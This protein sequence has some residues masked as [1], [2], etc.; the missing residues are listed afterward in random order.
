MA[1]LLPARTLAD[2]LADG[3]PSARFPQSGI[4]GATLRRL[5]SRVLRATSG[6]AG[7]GYAVAKRT[8][9]IVVAGAALAFAAPVLALAAAAIKL[10]SKGPVL[11]RQTRIGKDGQPF[12]MWKLRSMYAD[13]EARKAALAATSERTGA[14]KLKHDPRITRVGRLIRKASL[15]EIPQLF[16]VLDGTMSLVGPRPPLPDEVAAYSFVERGRLAVKPGITC[17]WQVSGRAD[18][19]FDRQVEL[20]L[21]YV[22]RPSLLTDLG[23]LCRTVPAVLTARGAY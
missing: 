1:S 6:R 8:L 13:A 2:C 14:F 19:A 10:E 22:Q 3:A 18:L 23:L 5:R 16:N 17:T 7:L 12:T 20:D 21:A 9:D 4:A 11:F 15:D